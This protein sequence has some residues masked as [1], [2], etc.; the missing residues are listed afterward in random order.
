[1]KSLSV[2]SGREESTKRYRL[3][4]VSRKLSGRLWPLYVAVMKPE[5]RELAAVVVASTLAE[6]RPLLVW[7]PMPK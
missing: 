3:L 6:P 5:P 4:P 1:M 2:Q 7:V